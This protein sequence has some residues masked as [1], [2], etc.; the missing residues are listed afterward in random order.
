MIA[1][2]LASQIKVGDILY[3]RGPMGVELK[4]TVSAPPA[5]SNDDGLWEWTSLLDDGTPIMYS[6]TAGME[7]YGPAFHSFPAYKTIP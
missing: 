1:G 2:K 4:T 6:V 3:E 5:K 7:H